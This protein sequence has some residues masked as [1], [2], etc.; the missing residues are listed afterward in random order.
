MTEASS[1]SLQVGLDCEHAKH[2]GSHVELDLAQMKMNLNMLYSRLLARIKIEISGPKIIHSRRC[3][4]L[5]G[6][7]SSLKRARSHMVSDA[8][9]ARTWYSA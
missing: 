7:P 6:K 1:V 9:F 4:A 8:A 3:G 5:I 2:V